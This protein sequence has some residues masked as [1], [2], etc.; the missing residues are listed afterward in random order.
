[1]NVPHPLSRAVVVGGGAM[2]AD[3]AE[4]LARAGGAVVLVEAG[5]A[6]RARLRERFGEHAATTD[7]TRYPYQVQVP[8]T[9]DLDQVDWHDV[10]LVVECVPEDLALKRAVFARLDALAPATTILASNSSALPVSRIAEGLA[11]ASRA[12]GLHFF[13]PA[14]LVPL[15]EVVLGP[16]TDP[17]H[18]EALREHLAARCAMVPVVVRRDLPGFLAN[19]LQHALAREA[20][21]LVESGVASADDVDAAVRYGFGFRFLAAGPVL[22]RDHAGLDVHA[23]AAAVI[24][25]TLCDADVPSRELTERVRAGRLGMKTGAGFRDWDDAAIAAERARYARVLRAALAIL[26]DEPGPDGRP[27]PASGTGPRDP[28]A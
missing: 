8:G 13:L 26:R 9:G 6:R 18:A 10:G 27:A 25:P 19:R 14:T 28:G 24:Y 20:F 17:A 21:A 16:A 3:I 2:G 11:G 23:A 22:Q 5:A 15:V 1:M 4:V 12:I 7:G